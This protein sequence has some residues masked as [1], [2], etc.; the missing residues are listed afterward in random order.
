M[1]ELS[2]TQML[3]AAQEGDEQ[4]VEKLFPM[5]YG[6]LRSIAHRQLISNVLSNQVSPTDL[7]HEAYIKLIDHQKV[8][9]KSRTHF[10]AIGYESCGRCL[11][12]G[13]A[14]I[15]QQSAAAEWHRCH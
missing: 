12:T 3:L 9:W 8:S 15:W 4:A 14:R 7:V 13:L 10:F 5:V 6:E 2:A 1:P 11:L